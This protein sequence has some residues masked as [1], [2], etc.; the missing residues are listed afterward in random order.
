MRLLTTALVF[1]ALA[2]G[3]HQ[4]RPSLTS[5]LPGETAPPVECGPGQ[6]YNPRLG[7]CVIFIEVPGGPGRWPDGSD[8][9]AWLLLK[10]K[11]TCF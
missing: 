2:P 4:E 5:I 7:R 9:V 8:A 11:D 1:I 10:Q 3:T 6:T